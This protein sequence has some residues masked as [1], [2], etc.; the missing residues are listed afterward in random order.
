MPTAMAHF[1]SSLGSMKDK[2]I[3][4]NVVALGILVITIVVNIW[5]QVFQLES[6]SHG[7][8]FVY[9]QMVPTISMLVLLVTF[10]SSAITLPTIKKSLESKYQ[11]M[12]KAA[13]TEERMVKR[14]QDCRIDKQ[15][16]IGMKKYWLMAETS[17]PQFVMA[18]SVLCTTSSV[19][20]LF[21][22]LYFVF[23]FSLVDLLK[24][25]TEGLRSYSVYGNNI[26]WI[27][28]VQ[29]IG[30]V[31]GTIVS[32]CRWFTAVRFKCLMTC[33]R[34]NF[35]EELKIE[36]H[37][38]QALV[39]WRDSFSGLQIQD[40]KCRRYLH[41]A[42]WFALTF[43][44][45]VQIMMVIASKLLLLS[46]ALLITPFI[47]FFKKL[48][49]QRLSRLTTSNN[50]IKSESGG[51]TELNL[52][53]FV[54][55]LDGEAEL[56][57]KTL[58]NICGQADKVIEMGKEQKPQN[59]IHL[60]NRFGNFSGVTEF[61]SF[62]VPSLHSQEP[63]NCWSLPLVTLTSIVISLPNI[64]NNHKATQLMSSVR[65]GLSLVNLIE[66]TLYKNDELLNIRNATEVS[67]VGIALYRKW[68]GL[69]LRR[70]SLKCKNVKN[71]LQELSSNAERKMVE[72]KRTTD[73][74]LTD[75]PLNWPTNI[76]AANSMYRICQTILLSCQDEKEQTA[77]GLFERLSIM[78]ADILAACFT[79]LARVIITM[80]RSNAIE[81]REKSV[82]EAFLLLG[83][84][85]QIL[86]LLQ[87]QEWRSWIM[88]KPH[89]LTSGALHSCRVI[90]IILL[91]HQ[92]QVMKQ[93]KVRSQVRS[94]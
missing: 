16:I 70:I 10:A 58:K 11:V 29:I 62:Q 69:D 75:Y 88:I 37:W 3:L 84:T 79:N 52:N 55:L 64:V 56:P 19:I 45:G 9:D 67:W 34:I 31:V 2:E 59:L 85:G 41:D 42:K 57:E 46:P 23:S 26:I 91:P 54:L 33:R 21:S 86:E 63:P 93:R 15:M 43:F 50:D 83:K 71:V 25:G 47:L 87:Q 1:M 77:D 89:T 82:H 14:G 80:C 24:P 48:K 73:V 38:I 40:N 51:D 72:F 27:L 36:A 8:T 18:R 65:E 68:Q 90:M 81:E 92:L 78:I 61:D 35:R 7:T 28:I 74:F 94:K 76:I 13:M 30:M 6:L 17:N 66:K 53:R 4:M 22:T 20:C 32:L 49:A 5:I 39:Y 12:H 44:I 60:L